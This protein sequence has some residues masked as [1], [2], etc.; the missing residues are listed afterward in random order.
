MHTMGRARRRARSGVK[1]RGNTDDVVAHAAAAGEDLASLA[2]F[3]ELI[4]ERSHDLITILEPGG[5]IVY[6]SPSWRSLGLD[7]DQIVGRRVLDFVHPD[8]VDM[9][10]AAIERALAGGD[11]DAITVRLRTTA[12][13]WA[14]Y[15]SNGSPIL[16]ADN[17]VAYLVGTSRDVSEREELRLRVAEVDALYR[18]ADSISRA[19]SLDELLDEAIDILLGA[20]GADRAA[21]LLLDDEGAMRFRAWRGLSDEYRAG[22]EGHSPWAADVVDPEPVLVPDLAGAQFPEEL[23]R[24]VHAEGISA[25]AF[26]PLVHRARLLGKFMLYHDRPH[27]WNDAEVMLSRT[28]ASH[29]AS[30]TVRTQAQEALRVSSEQLSTIMR[31]VD[32]GIVMQ[33]Q[34]GALVYVNEAAARFVGF[35]TTSEF[36]NASRERVLAQF[37]ILDDERRPLPPEALPGRRALRGEASEQVVCY[38]ILSTGEERWS[39]VR[40]NPVHDA[41]GQVMLSVSVI[42]D[43]TASRNA[44]ERARESTALVEGVF[45]TVPVG[46]AFWDVDLRYVRVNEALEQMYGVDASHLLGR[47][48]FE[49]RPEYVSDLTPVIQQVLE[50][51]SPVL[52]VEVSGERRDDPGVRRV[53]VTSFFP[54]HDRA[55]ELLGVGCSTSDVTAERNSLE[56][57]ARAEQRIRFLARA[58]DMLNETLDYERTLAA[59]AEM[60]VPTFAGQVVIDVL[61]DDGS[62][63]CVGAAHADPEK[64]QYVRDLRRRYPPTADDHPVQRAI[65]TGDHVYLADVQEHVDEMAHDA[66]HAEE[67]RRLANTSGIVVPLIARGRTLGT[68][69]LGTVDPQP[70]F[71]DADVE[72]AIELARR[73]SLALDNARLYREAQ[74]RAHAASALEFVDDG[75]FLLD[76]DDVIRLWNPAAAQTFRVKPAKAIGRPVGELIRD[77]SAVQDRIRIAAEPSS[78][79]GRAQTVPVDVQGDERWLS[80]SAVRFPGG[81]VYAFRDLTDERAVDQLKSDFVATVSH[82]LRTPLSAIYGAALTLRRDDVRLEESQ[83]DGLLDVVASESDRLARIVNDILWASRLDSGQMGVAIESCDA[84]KL[85]NQVV[86]AVRAHAPDN[87]ELVVEALD[88]LPAVAT[89][90]DKLRQVLT[91]LVDNAVKYSPDGGRVL[92]AV[93]HTGKRIRFRVED[94]GLGIPPSE[95]TRIFEKFFRLDP[96]MT[97]GVGGTGLGL[98]ICRELVYRMHGRIWVSSDGRSG[99]IFNVELPVAT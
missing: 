96:G 21:V 14:W 79:S 59:I 53:W 28:I 48:L 2:A 34:S 70:R 67:I 6:G 26:V 32:E 15:E 50:T 3:Q 37:E 46:L 10:A 83:R 42:R 60:A 18:I 20:T 23:E 98:Y 76:G 54:V 45:R 82:E 44:E 65:R 81:T 56:E 29:L 72:L 97:R 13:G 33:A 1:M 57:R 12:G 93:A 91:N 62:V 40:A 35:E 5:T 75:V 78:G 27:V 51:G 71:T 4:L 43:I 86:N 66:A 55:G 63:R 39:V 31:T 16:G 7:P 38:R 25:L 88:G 24:V 36:L 17:E 94:H 95:Q 61:D 77:W 74:G 52:D 64:S 89:D 73:A 11:F 8:D 99:S 84:V 49:L 30:A 58:G 90:P 22:A 80:I 85:A 68:I 92:V 19:T 9:A 87:I 47:T 69:Q 41:A